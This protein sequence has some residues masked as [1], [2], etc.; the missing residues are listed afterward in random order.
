MEA[1]M[2]VTRILLGMRGIT[3]GRKQRI[4]KREPRIVICLLAICALIFIQPAQADTV[5]DWNGIATTAARIQGPSPVPQTRTYAMVHAAVHDALNA[6][7]RR[8]QP[9]AYAP[10]TQELLNASPDAAVATAAY[11]VL[12]HVL[13]LPLPPATK[14]FLD[15][16]YDQSLSRIPFGAAKDDGIAIGKAAAAAII[17]LRSSDGFNPSEPPPYTPGSG[18]GV[19]I[20]TPPGFSPAAITWWGNVPPFCLRSGAQFRLDRPEFFD[21]SSKEYAANYNEVKEIGERDNSSRSPD[22]SD[23]AQF[24][25]E[26]SA[27]GWNRIA[28][29]VSADHPLLDLWENARLF[30]LVNFALAD[31][32]IAHFDTKYFYNFWRPVT[33]IQAGDTDGNDATVADTGWTSFLTTPNI[34]DYPS[35]HSTVGAAVAF[36][37]AGFFGQDEV[38]FTTT[39]GAPFPGIT[40]SF[41]SF[42]QAALENA[43]SR[44]FAGIHF[45]T[46]CRDGVR[47]GE[48]VGR[49]VLNHSLKPVQP[50][51]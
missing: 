16:A 40:R 13:P 17:A 28:R 24:W 11:D 19:W 29:S 42:S 4:M 36:V 43:D 30:G 34:P 6:I 8:Y 51:K 33:A 49:F 14:R 1:R 38:P 31:G 21:L 44:V 10:L 27:Q 3:I 45:R 2:K 12:V 25:Y 41:A 7:D 50:A 47:L 26:A 35:G 37:L 32:Y 46:S 22:Q 48:R 20:P 23:T 15:D 39:S 18:P 9:Y 5:T